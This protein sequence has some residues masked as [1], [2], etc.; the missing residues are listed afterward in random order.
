Y[1][2]RING[3][4]LDNYLDWMRSL[5]LISATGCPAVSV[6]AGFSA[7]GLPVGVQIV[8]RPGAD[9]ELLRIAHAFEAATAHH[10]RQPRLCGTGLANLRGVCRAF[11]HWNGSRKGVTI[12]SEQAERFRLDTQRSNRCT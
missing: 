12:L 5:C 7:S 4:E 11:P 10:T 8:A 3:V 6:P 9:V 2:T 1:P